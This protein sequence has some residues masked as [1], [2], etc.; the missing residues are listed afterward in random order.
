MKVWVNV[1][2]VSTRLPTKI[3]GRNGVLDLF[4]RNPALV[5][6]DVAKSE[7][8]KTI[9]TYVRE[10]SDIV[11]YAHSADGKS[12]AL[13]EVCKRIEHVPDDRRPGRPSRAEPQLTDWDEFVEQVEALLRLEAVNAE[14]RAKGLLK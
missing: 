5:R 1:N 9:A 10:G 13:R 4:D 14:R 11:W 3:A 8:G 12:I 6:L 7:N 2:D